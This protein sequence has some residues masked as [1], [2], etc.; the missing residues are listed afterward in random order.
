MSEGPAQGQDSSISEN[1]IDA[2]IAIVGNDELETIME[3]NFQLPSM[4]NIKKKSVSFPPVITEEVVLSSDENGED[5][6]VNA[7]RRQ[8]A[9][10]KSTSNW[11]ISQ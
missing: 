3:P 7:Y 9:I 2:T 8:N 6:P 1:A 10:R 11:F 4:I 5:R